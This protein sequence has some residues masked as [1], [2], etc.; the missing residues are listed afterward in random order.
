MQMFKKEWTPQASSEIIKT[1]WLVHLATTKVQTMAQEQVV[2]KALVEW[3]ISKRRSMPWIKILKFTM[4]N[5]A[6]KTIHT[7]RNM[8]R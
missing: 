3:I 6:S 8:V 2:D 7:F 4:I 5:G 1:T